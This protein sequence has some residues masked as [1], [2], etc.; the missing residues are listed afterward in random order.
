M[1][2]YIKASLNS[3]NIDEYIHIITDGVMDIVDDKDAEKHRIDKEIRDLILKEIFNTSEEEI[4][5]LVDMV[6][7]NIDSEYFLPFG[8]V[9]AI[10]YGDL[11]YDTYEGQYISKSADKTNEPG[12]LAYSANRIGLSPYQLNKALEGMCDEA[13][14]GGR[15]ARIDAD[16][17]YVGTL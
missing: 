5:K 4:E 14:D 8:Y 10:K 1:Y 9:E 6:Y 7:E 3:A 12:G 2:R 11:I 16:T 15:V 17:Y 13:E